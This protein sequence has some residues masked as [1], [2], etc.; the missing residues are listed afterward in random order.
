MA[1][2][3]INTNQ[4]VDGAVATADIADG[5]ITTAKLADNAVTTAKTTDANIT[6]AKLADDAVTTAKIT[7]GNI[8]TAKVADDAVTQAKIGA[9]AVGTTE[10]ANDVVINTS[11]TDTTLATFTNTSG[12][13]TSSGVVHVK[14]S[15]A[16]NNPTMVLEQTGAGGNSGDTQGLHIK[17]AGQNQGTGKAIRVTTTN[18]NL[19]SGN[20]Y[21]PF[22]VNNGGEIEVKNSSNQST[23]NLSSAGYLTK[24][25]HP[26][27]AVRRG[28]SAGE[29]MVNASNSHTVAVP[30]TFDTEELD[31]FNMFNNS[32]YKIS[33]PVSGVYAFH[34][35]VLTGILIPSSGVNWCSFNLM[36]N[37][38]TGSR[39]SG[40]PQMYEEVYN[41]SGSA[42]AGIGGSGRY[43]KKVTGSCQVY[44]SSSDTVRLMF[45]CSA[46]TNA[47]IHSGDHSTFCGYLLG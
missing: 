21:D 36:L 37:D 38:S 42:N 19:N 47:R 46:S 18:S 7:D 25:R 8:T 43:F 29:Q 6:T 10:L 41:A 45:Y 44:V 26:Y 5:L 2:S 15:N 4:I 1:L 28:N 30:V 11:S 17:M 27:F 22:M 32:T 12:N 40:T 24:P 3:R 23:L 33:I 9:D 39:I 31:P 20:A 14:Q 13:N 16:T 35:S 34:W